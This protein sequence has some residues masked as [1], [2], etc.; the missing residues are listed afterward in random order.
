MP[1]SDREA[2]HRKRKNRPSPDSLIQVDEK[3]PVGNS[4]KTPNYLRYTKLRPIWEL[5]LRRELEKIIRR[6]GHKLLQAGFI[7]TDVKGQE[8]EGDTFLPF[9]SETPMESLVLPASPKFKR[10]AKNYLYKSLNHVGLKVLKGYNEHCRRSG[11]KIINQA[12]VLKQ[13]TATHGFKKSRAIVEGF[14]RMSTPLEPKTKIAESSSSSS[15][16][17]LKK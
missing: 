6:N 4:V 3:T 11:C 12:A 17:N 9:T 5:V 10:T 14:R 1:R 16:K 15:T 13:L 2:T 8:E 7:S